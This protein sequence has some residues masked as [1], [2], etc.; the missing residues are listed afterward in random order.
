MSV[1]A[2]LS[3]NSRFSKPQEGQV[4]HLSAS[5]NALCTLVIAAGRSRC[6]GLPAGACAAGQCRRL[7]PPGWRGI[8]ICGRFR[9]WGRGCTPLS[10]LCKAALILVCRECSCPPHKVPFSFLKKH[11]PT[12]STRGDL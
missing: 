1:S 4:H 7:R 5:C 12:F 8:C 3:L 6:L 10:P 2:R 9:R 11:L